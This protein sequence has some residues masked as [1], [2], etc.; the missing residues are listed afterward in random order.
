MPETLVS[1]VREIEGKQGMIDELSEKST[2][3][4]LKFDWNKTVKK[5]VKFLFD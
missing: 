3:Q 2:K 5:T 1:K 4:A